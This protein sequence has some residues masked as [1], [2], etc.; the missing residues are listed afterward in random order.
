MQKKQEKYEI[1]H[2]QRAIFFSSCYVYKMVLT[3]EGKELYYQNSI[4][5][6]LTFV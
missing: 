1:T 3:L 6:K 5:N 2:T 4:K